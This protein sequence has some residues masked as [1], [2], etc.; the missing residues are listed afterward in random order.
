MNIPIFTKKIVSFNKR[1]I[2]V[3]MLNFVK[4]KN[5]RTSQQ[6]VFQTF[7]EYTL[8][9][10]RYFDQFHAIYLLTLIFW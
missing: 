8:K 2:Q 6:K 3:K 1:Q 9:P 10:S 4:F 5:G 7:Q